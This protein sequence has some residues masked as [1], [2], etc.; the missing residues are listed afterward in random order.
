MIR[1][2]DFSNNF[3]GP[4]QSFTV[5]SAYS[6]P[7]I[8]PTNVFITKQSITVPLLWGDFFV[9]ANNGLPS[10]YWT[11]LQEAN[12][13][14]FDIERSSDGVTFVSVNRVPAS[15]NTSAP[16]AYHFFDK[17]S[18]PLSLYYYRLKEIDI[19]GHYTYSKICSCKVS[20]LKEQFKMLNNVVTDKLGVMINVKTNVFISDMNGKMLSSFLLTP[21]LHQ[22]DLS[23]LSA[24]VYNIAFSSGNG[25][26]GIKRF[27]K[28]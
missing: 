5:P 23:T 27:V 16:S 9:Q 13:T 20:Q 1:T 6:A 22:I 28:L 26:T 17:D 21:G 19:D 12:T 24:G 15:G 4:F 2:N 7:V 18:L 3:S 8:V 10:L 11:T 14:Y 25:K